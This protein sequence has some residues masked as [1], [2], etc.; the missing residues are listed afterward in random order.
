MN[1]GIDLGTT[2]TV[3]GWMNLFGNIEFL[4]FDENQITLPS[5]IYYDRGNIIVGQIG[6]ASCRERVSNYV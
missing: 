6:R 4:E 2:N 1:I 3:V 5:C